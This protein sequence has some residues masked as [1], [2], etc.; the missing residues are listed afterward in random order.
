MKNKKNLDEVFFKKLVVKISKLIGRNGLRNLNKAISVA[1]SDIIQ[2]NR[3]KLP[4]D[5]TVLFFLSKQENLSNMIE[6]GVLKNDMPLAVIKKRT[7]DYKR[8]V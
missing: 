2:K 6:S 1:Q 4:K 8:T 7:K 5:W 3:E